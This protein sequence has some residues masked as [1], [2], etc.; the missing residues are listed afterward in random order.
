LAGQGCIRA[1]DFDPEGRKAVEPKWA[2]KKQALAESITMQ[3]LLCVVEL[4]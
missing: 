2:G 4:R 3:N 1:G